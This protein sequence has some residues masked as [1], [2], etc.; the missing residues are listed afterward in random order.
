M[1]VR[2]VNAKSCL[3]SISE[4]CQ[5]GAGLIVALGLCGC[6]PFL[7][8]KV[9]AN[10]SPDLA[11]YRIS[12]VA[13]L[14]VEPLS[15]PQAVPAMPPSLPAPQGA[16]RSDM[17]VVVPGPPHQR[18]TSELSSVPPQAAEKATSLFYE[19]LQTRPGLEVVSP[20]ESRRVSSEI[21]KESSALTAEELAGKV[22]QKLGADG[23]LVGRL[24]VYQERPGSKW[25]GEPATVGFEVKLVAHDGTTLWVGNY[26]ERQRP[27]IE[28]FVGWIE[29]GGVFV[30]ADELMEYGVRKV[31]KK[32]PAP[33]K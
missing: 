22:A 12:T 30:T 2:G 26:Y 3:G 7:S 10:T 25:G 28:D 33:S 29:R 23:A 32:F 5:L 31:F 24:L 1:A 27:M 17:N 15:T 4:A 21:K 11:K 9:I 19:R 14:P 18:L 6:T 8:S 20:E 13:L 16:K